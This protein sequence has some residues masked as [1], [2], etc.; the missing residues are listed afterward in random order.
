MRAMNTTHTAMLEQS[1]TTK[2]YL[3]IP[4]TCSVLCN[5]P[6]FLTNFKLLLTEHSRSFLCLFPSCSHTEANSWCGTESCKY[7]FRIYPGLH[8]DEGA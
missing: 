1:W 8:F 2:S 3:R 4:V 7:D 5:L 6:S